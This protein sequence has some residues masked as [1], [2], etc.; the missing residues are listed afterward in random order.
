MGKGMRLDHFGDKPLGEPAEGGEGEG[1]LPRRRPAGAAPF[2]T[3]SE[4]TDLIEDDLRRDDRLR[5]VFVKGEISGLREYPRAWYFTLKDA[6]S[7]IAGVCWNYGATRE[8]GA[9][10]KEGA[11]VIARGDVT[12][13]K[14]RGQYQLRVTE[15]QPTDKRGALFLKFE[16]TKK[17][18]AAE[19]L[20]DDAKKRPLPRFPRIVGVVTSTEGAVVRDIIN[21]VTRRFP[22]VRLLVAPA[23]VQGEGAEHEVIRGIEAL[24]RFGGVEV[25]IV[26]R[27]GGSIEDLWPFNEEAL[28]RAVRAS[29]VPVVSAVG[30]QTDFTICDFAAD[31]RAPTP[32]A[33]AEIVVPDAEEVFEGFEEREARFTRA[34]LHARDRA[35]GKLERLTHHPALRI[36]RTLLEARQQMLDEVADRLRNTSGMA[37]ERATAR[38]D[39]QT[40][41][42][43]VLSP[44]KT[45]ARGYAIALDRNGSVLRSASGVKV[46]DD[47]DVLLSE[48]EIA[49]K[50]QSKGPGRLGP[51]PAKGT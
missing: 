47:V 22:H 24:N 42:L 17:K 26:A 31:V 25:I 1:E 15:I 11:E 6:D 30:H 4:L 35:A 44:L 14:Q 21:V 28:A 16:Q 33:A 12:V 29:A 51:R 18:L 3:V 10:L 41:A 7:M 40:A 20:F 5:G 23:R 36:P 38:L 9:Q 50:V 32:S 34:L 49:T 27:G 19:G 48:G 2:F 8:V 13:Y 37:I 46:G 43:D 39:R 45:L